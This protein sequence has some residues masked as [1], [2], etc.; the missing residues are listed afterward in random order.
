MHL[1]RKFIVVVDVVVAA[2][3]VGPNLSGRWSLLQKLNSVAS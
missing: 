2:A 1:S 3:L